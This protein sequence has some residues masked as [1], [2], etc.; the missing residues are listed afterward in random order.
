MLLL[1]GLIDTEFDLC[2]MHACCRYHAVGGAGRMQEAMHVSPAKAR[3]TPEGREGS[4]GMSASPQG[5]TSS[6]P[7]AADSS[8]GSEDILGSSQGS[9]GSSQGHR[10]VSIAVGNIAGSEAFEN[11]AGVGTLG[12]PLSPRQRA[13]ASPPHGNADVTLNMSGMMPRRGQLPS[14][15]SPA[16]HPLSRVFKVVFLGEWVCA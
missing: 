9:T 1:W 3:H 6:S 12:Q 13:V 14:P 15:P 7:G 10:G 8:Q 5:S 2:A 11:T 16:N 4:Q